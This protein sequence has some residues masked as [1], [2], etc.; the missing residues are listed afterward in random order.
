MA[1]KH[2]LLCKISP[3]GAR[4]RAEG[5]ELQEIASETPAWQAVAYYEMQTC[6]AHG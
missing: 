2:P 1:G 6:L 4:A 3:L 5:H